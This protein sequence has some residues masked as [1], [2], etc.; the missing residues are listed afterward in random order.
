MSTPFAKF[1]EGPLLLGKELLFFVNEGT[2]YNK[3][4]F[5]FFL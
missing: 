3:Q 2:L 4:R 1:I 5:S